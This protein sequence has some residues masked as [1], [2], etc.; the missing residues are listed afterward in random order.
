MGLDA[1]PFQWVPDKAKGL[2]RILNWFIQGSDKV[3]DR[4]R[5]FWFLSGSDG[6]VC[7]ALGEFCLCFKQG[8]VACHTSFLSLTWLLFMRFGCCIA[9]G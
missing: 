3:A 7:D 2:G 5:S 1:A 6:G 8:S 9:V 4:D